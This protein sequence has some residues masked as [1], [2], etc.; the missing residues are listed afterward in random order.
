MGSFNGVEGSPQSMLSNSMATTP[1]RTGITRVLM[2]SDEDRGI[3]SQVWGG[4]PA[5]QRLL[6]GII[7]SCIPKPFKLSQFTRKGR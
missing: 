3:V 6:K 5:S 4:C 2:L 1:L 7:P